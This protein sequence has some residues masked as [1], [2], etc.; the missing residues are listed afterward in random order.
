MATHFAELRAA[1][2]RLLADRSFF[3]VAVLTLALGVGSVSAIFSVVSGVLLKPLPYADA[4]RIV[5]VIRQQG[6]WSGPVSPTVLEAW[7]DGTRE[8]FSGLAAFSMHTVNATGNGE[9]ERLAGYRVSPEFWGVMAHNAA[10]GRYFTAEED[11]ANERVVV[12]GHQHWIS[13]YGADPDIIGRDIVLNGLSHR[14]VGIAPASFRYPG[15]AQIYLPAY[16]GTEGQGRGNFLMVIGRLAPGATLQQADAALAVVN[17]RL[18]ADT[19]D[20]N[21]GLGARLMP[22]PE[23]LTSGVRQPLLVLLGASA[24][25]LL[26]ACANLA[27]LLLARGS[28]RR[29]ELA[30]RAALGAG[31]GRL[32]QGVLSEAMVIAVSGGVLG[33]IVAGLAVP[34]LLSMGSGVV[35]EHARPDV[36]PLVVLVSLSA[37]ILTVLLF[38]L[39]PALRAASASP[40]TAL[41]DDG[42]SSGGGGGRDRARARSALVVA[43]VALSLTLLVGAGLLIESLRQL[44]QVDTGVQSGNVLTAALVLDGVPPVPG[45]EVVDLYRRHTSY[46]APRLDAVLAR[47]ATIP[48]VERVGLSD[49]LPMSGVDNISGDIAIVG[50]DVAA[51]QPQ[52]YGSWRFVNPDF[53]EAFGIPVVRGRALE[54]GDQRPGDMPRSVLV[55]ESFVRRFLPDAEPIGQQ[56]LYF[57]LD[58]DPVSI[59][60]VVGDTRLHG[61]DRDIAPEVYMAH[62]NATQ[63]QFY[64]A[65]KVRGEPIAYAEQL[66]QAIRELDPDIPVFEIRSMDGMIADTLQ[67]R[68]FNM[69]LMSVFSAVAVVLTALGLYGVIA[70]SVAQRRHEIGIR[71]S[72]GARP[73]AVLRQIMAQGSRLV[74]AGVAIGLIGAV[75][76]GRVIAAQLYGTQPTDPLVLVSVSVTLVGIGLLSCG[77]PAWRAARIK[78]MQALRHD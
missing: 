56:L 26:I 2:R 52:P 61:L 24:L 69:S 59:V 4:E 41:R 23:V 6:N 39:G 25:V 18:A 32:I 72:L 22:L 70:Y 68:R 15:S 65:L 66:R 33:L 45:E 3:A 54:P 1:S 31:R 36:D 67:M 42:R 55:N 20:E 43:E 38:A 50:R 28:R 60:G 47:L 78:P 35:P 73:V 44:G 37:A 9:A 13:R 76:L 58:P 46:I 75:L 51:G 12:L 10:L 8:V 11:S 7:R 53:F 63:N 19:P 16:L 40:G 5:R 29:S 77:M 30:L 62:S 64:L 48:G 71:L 17:A 14:V 74:L 34:A 49:A 21:A 27:N 57:G